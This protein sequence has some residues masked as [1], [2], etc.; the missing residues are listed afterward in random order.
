MHTLLLCNCVCAFVH[1]QH[2]VMH[3]SDTRL[4][5]RQSWPQSSA[6]IRLTNSATHRPDKQTHTKCS[7]AVLHFR[8]SVIMMIML[9]EE[10]EKFRLLSL[11]LA[12]VTRL[13]TYL[14]TVQVHLT[15]TNTEVH[16]DTCS[17]M[18]V[19]IYVCVRC[20]WAAWAG[21]TQTGTRYTAAIRCCATF[22]HDVTWPSRGQGDGQMGRGNQTRGW[23]QQMGQCVFSF[24]ML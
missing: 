5:W 24:S 3:I 17:S 7:Y 2:S 6:R 15:H 22:T 19:C 16:P 20:C 21:S 14:S 12:P 13:H 4:R 23:S 18:C 8:V 11:L 1:S 10:G 9:Q